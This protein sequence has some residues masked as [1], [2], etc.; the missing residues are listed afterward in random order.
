MSLRIVHHPNHELIGLLIRERLRHRLRGGCYAPIG[1]GVREPT[2]P[3]SQAFRQNVIVRAM[4][5]Y[6]LRAELKKRAMELLA[7]GDWEAGLL[8]L[9]DLDKARRGVDSHGRR[10]GRPIAV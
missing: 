5:N 4:R 1:G 3:G 7:S 8:I 10:R 9:E 2:L 6:A